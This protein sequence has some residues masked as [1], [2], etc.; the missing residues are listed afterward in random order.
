MDIILKALKNILI[1]NTKVK[2]IVNE[3]NDHFYLKI[4]IER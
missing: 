2:G 3:N 1:L 4:G